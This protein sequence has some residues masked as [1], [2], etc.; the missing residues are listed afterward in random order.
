MKRTLKIMKTAVLVAGF[1]F[2]SAEH[3]RHGMCL[4]EGNRRVAQNRVSNGKEK[5]REQEMQ[6]RQKESFRRFSSSFT[7]RRIDFLH[8]IAN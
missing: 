8:S 4:P 7:S 5:E 6:K 3:C 2:R 1:R